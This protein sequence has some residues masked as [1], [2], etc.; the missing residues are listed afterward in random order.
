MTDEIRR[1]DGVPDGEFSDDEDEKREDG[2]AALGM[3]GGMGAG[4]VIGGIVGGPVGTGLGI[5]A[6]MV[7]G[8]LAGREVGRAVNAK[9]EQEYWRTHYAERPYVTADR[10]YDDLAPAYRYGWEARARYP[11]R[12]W[13]E[14]EPDLGREWESRSDR[15]RLTWMDARPAARDA[16]DRVDR[17][18][19]GG[20]PEGGP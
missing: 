10:T 15:P 11:E 2:G 6:G 13:D 12:A 4:A 20:A 17:A 14:V 3:A 8:G 19:R 5:A 9:A 18:G 1:D 16:W 7:A